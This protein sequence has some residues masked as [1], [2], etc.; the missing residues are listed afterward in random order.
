MST[1]AFL[2]SIVLSTCLWAPPGYSQT[3]EIV[4]SAATPGLH[5]LPEEL[6]AFWA[7]TE[8]RRVRARE[9][10]Q[11]VIDK[12]PNSYVAHTV[13]GEVE[14]IAEGN[15]P[16]AV[17]LLQRALTLFEIAHANQAD[18]SN[19]WRWHSRIL[20]KLAFAQGDMENHQEK[21]ELLERYNQLYE[22]DLLAQRVW[23]LL[24]LGRYEDAR[25]AARQG[26]ASGNARQ[27]QIALNA[28]CAI[29][30]EIDNP[31]EYYASCSRAVEHA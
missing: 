2:L 31:A 14:Q 28:L 22:P 15:F 29:A 3:R 24:K 18:T 23:P 16:R 27:Q 20:R 30:A 7:F 8:G 11:S 26:M 21:L 12:N 4:A 25:E 5:A 19:T 1:R 17:Y 6:E 10:A 13:L 9:L